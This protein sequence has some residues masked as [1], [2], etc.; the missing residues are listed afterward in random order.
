[1]LILVCFSSNSINISTHPFISKGGREVGLPL[2]GEV[3][4][5]SSNIY[6]IGM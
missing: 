2:H 4:E 1:M 5:G 3:W 6:A